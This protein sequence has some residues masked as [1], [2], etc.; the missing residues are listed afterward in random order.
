MLREPLLRELETIVA[1]Q[2]VLTP[3]ESLRALSHDG[4]TSLI[5]EPDVVVFSTNAEAGGVK[6]T[7]KTKL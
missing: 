2:N 6:N 7:L 4:T 1:K 5:H 3:P